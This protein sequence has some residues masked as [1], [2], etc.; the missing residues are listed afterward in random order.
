V[1]GNRC[2]RILEPVLAAI[3]IDQLDLPHQPNLWSPEY[4]SNCGKSVLAQN[5][6]DKSRPVK[7][8]IEAR[9]KL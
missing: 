2:E 9:S 3:R 8:M 4:K 7:H 1:G 5:L 6:T